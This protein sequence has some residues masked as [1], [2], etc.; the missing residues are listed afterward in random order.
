VINRGNARQRVFQKQG[1]YQTLLVSK[2]ACGR[3]DDLE[4]EAKSRLSPFPDPIF[5]L[6][7]SLLRFVIRCDGELMKEEKV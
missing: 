4:T 7:V 6:R 3:E 5:M 1:D 2:Q